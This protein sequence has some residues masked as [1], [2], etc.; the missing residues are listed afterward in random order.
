VSDDNRRSQGPSSDEVCR[1]LRRCWQPVARAQDLAAGPQRTVLLG[2]ALAVFLTESGAPAVV[3]DRCAHRGASLS[4]GEVTGESVQC[5]Y[6]GWEWAGKDG[7]CTRI[8]SL[9]DQGQIP[10]RARIP[11]FPA[12]VQWGLVWT[13]LEEPLTEPPTVPW[14]DPQ[15]WTWGHGTPF[16]LPVG[17]GLMIENFRDVAHFA[18]IHQA[19]L[20]AMPEVVEPLEPERDGLVVTLRREMSVGEGTAEDIYGPRSEVRFHT[21][22]PNFTSAQLLTSR[23]ERCLLHAARAI[24]ATESAHYWIKGL[25]KGFEVE[26]LEEAIAFEERIYA[27]DRPIVSAIEPPELPVDPD[28]NINSL[29]DRFTLAYRQ[30]FAEFVERALGESTAQSRSIAS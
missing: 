3:A 21:I 8:P 18:F 17:L 20:G 28:A 6:H 4:M 15:R 5:P 16:E 25:G 23:G 19:T 9:A 11:A 2:E 7:S 13:V 14:F 22:A 27:E 10:P 26:D 29:A 30:A 12:R 24:S 1:A